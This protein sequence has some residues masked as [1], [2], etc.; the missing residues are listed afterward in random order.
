MYVQVAYLIGSDKVYEREFGNLEKIKDN[1]KKIVLLLDK[2]LAP[3]KNGIE[4][5]NLVDFLMT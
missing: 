4:W 2:H 3:N 5:M 1:H